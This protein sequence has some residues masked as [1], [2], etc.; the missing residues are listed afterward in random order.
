MNPFDLSGPEFLAFYVALAVIV[1]GFAVQYRRMKEWRR[2][3]KLALD[4][5]V[6]AYLRGGANEALRVALVSLIDRG[7]LTALTTQVE[8]APH[9]D[10]AVARLPIEKLLLEKF[11]KAGKAADIFTDPKLVAACGPFRQMLEE[12]G[13]LPTDAVRWMRKTVQTVAIV[14]LQG[15]A[16]IKLFVALSRGRYNVIF[17]IVLMFIAT[18]VTVFL[19]NPRRT[20]AGDAFLEDLRALYAG[21]AGRA[22]AI[23]PGGETI[24]TLMLAAV[25]GVSVLPFGYA[26]TL[27]PKASKPGLSG[28]SSCGSSSGSACGSSC[29]SSCGGGGCGGGC[30]GCGS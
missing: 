23:R 18:A 1:I 21:L 14:L 17:L 27:F 30:G 8:I 24:E 3:P 6:I 4:P 20:R 22:R 16:G 10:P 7:L 9:A 19:C 29:G 12:Q 15:T 25:F 11:R 26:K 28:S 5:Y 2:P 13:L